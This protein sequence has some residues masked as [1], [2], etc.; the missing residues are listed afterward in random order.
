MYQTYNTRAETAYYNESEK[1]EDTCTPTW[2][3][4]CSWTLCRRI[5]F[6]ELGKP[7]PWNPWDT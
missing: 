4:V 7:D 3:T 6:V 2:L 5:P 1:H